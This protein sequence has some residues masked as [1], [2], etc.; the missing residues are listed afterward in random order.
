[1]AAA[2]KCDRCGKFYTENTRFPK[3]V[4]ISR[5]VLDGICFTTK[6]GHCVDYVDLCDDCIV[7]LKSFLN[8]TEPEEV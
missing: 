8:G 4:N 6:N 7:K 5:S 3:T 2:K 1:M